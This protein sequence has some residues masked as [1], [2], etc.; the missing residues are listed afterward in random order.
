[1]ELR[2]HMVSHTG[3]MPYKVRLGLS[4]GPGLGGPRI[5]PAE[6]FTWG[7]VRHLPHSSCQGACLP[8][9]PCLSS[10][11]LSRQGLLSAAS[12]PRSLLGPCFFPWRTGLAS[13]GQL[14]P[15]ALLCTI[16]HTRSG[17]LPESSHRGL[18][19]VPAL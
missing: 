14:S 1:M 19:L 6:P 16:L 7:A 18:P 4:P 12:P 9:L 3:E 11:P 13:S 10:A 2:V 17:V 15:E 5:L 8:C